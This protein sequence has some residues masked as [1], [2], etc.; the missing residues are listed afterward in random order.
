MRNGRWSKQ[1]DYGAGSTADSGW[2]GG[3]T[4]FSDNRDFPRIAE[5]L[6]Q[7]GFNEAELGLGLGG[8]WAKLL[9]RV[10]TSSFE[11]SILDA[12]A[13][14]RQRIAQYPR[15][16]SAKCCDGSRVV[17]RAERQPIELYPLL[18]AANGVSAM[19][20]HHPAFN[21]DTVAPYIV[22]KRP[23]AVTIL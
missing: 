19:A 21:A 20:D 4:W 11:T 9:S 2:P 23:M 13:N 7:K 12:P 10:A 5:A 8:N 15:Y 17:R 1:I 6:S 16:W 14:V 3:L 18:F 22:C